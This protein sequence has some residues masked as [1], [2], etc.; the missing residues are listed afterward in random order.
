MSD[1]SMKRPRMRQDILNSAVDLLPCLVLVCG[2]LV[3]HKATAQLSSSITSFAS[4]F[5]VACLDIAILV[6]NV[7]NASET[8][9][10]VV[11]VSYCQ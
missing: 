7:S 4:P 2:K 9:V 6:L 3:Q 10:N 11:Q 8:L 1:A 5:T